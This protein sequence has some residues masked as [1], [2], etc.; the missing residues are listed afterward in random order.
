MKSV[1]LCVVVV[2]VEPKIN[3]QEWNGGALNTVERNMA[4]R[5]HPHQ[6]GLG[7]QFSKTREGVDDLSGSFLSEDFMIPCTSSV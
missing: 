7:A 4:G 2:V 5:R 6:A 1:S 3:G